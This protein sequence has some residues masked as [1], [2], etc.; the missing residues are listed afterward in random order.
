MVASMTTNAPTLITGADRDVNVLYPLEPVARTISQRKKNREL[1]FLLSER[2]GEDR[3]ASIERAL[4][5]NA[6]FRSAVERALTRVSRELSPPPPRV[7]DQSPT[8][9]MTGAALVIIAAIGI[10]MLCMGWLP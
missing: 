1:A 3:I 9:A 6:V 2:I 5:T 4:E 7:I 10:A 8:L